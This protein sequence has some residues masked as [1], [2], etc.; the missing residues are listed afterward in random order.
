MLFI[1]ILAHSQFTPSF[2]SLFSI[3]PSISVLFQ[4]PVGIPCCIH[5]SLV[6]ILS[7]SLMGLCDFSHLISGNAPP[8]TCISDSVFQN[9]TSKFS[10]HLNFNVTENK[11]SAP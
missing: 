5:Y 10:R 1:W 9:S 6:S 7:I 11:L 2:F 3:T 4:D 8:Q